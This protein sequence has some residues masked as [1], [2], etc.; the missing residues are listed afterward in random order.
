MV[1]NTKYEYEDGRLSAIGLVTA[2][3]EKLPLPLLE[4]YAQLFFMPLVLQLVND[5]SKDCREAVA[6]CLSRL[7]SRASVDVVQSFYDYAVRW[8]QGT[9][10]LQRTSLQLF[11]MFVDARLD[12]MKR[13]NNAEELIDRIYIHLKRSV[14]GGLDE[15]EVPY[16]S[17]VCLEKL[18]VPFSTL[19]AQRSDLWL[20][21]VECLV[22][23][24]PWV[25]QVSSRMVGTH[26]AAMDPTTFVSKKAETFLL[27]ESGS[28]FEVAQNLC[29]QLNVGEPEQNKE[30]STTAIKSLTWIIQ[31]MDEHP[32]LCFADDEVSSEEDDPAQSRKNP[33]TWL[34]TRLS[35]MAKPKGRQ[36]RENVFKC[37]AAFT[38]YGGSSIVSP[39][40]VLMLE[41]LHRSIVEVENVTG[42]SYNSRRTSETAEEGN[43][44]RDVLQLL[45]DSCGT[46]S[47]LEAY[48]SVKVRA[49]EKREQ[50]KQQLATEAVQDPQ[51]AATRK[52]KKHQ[53]ERKR[54]K[55]KVEERRNR[56]G[57]FA[58][59]RHVDYD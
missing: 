50:R 16:F 49:R 53:S 45:E 35:N 38:T 41:P 25:K 46:D 42:H 52:I 18:S 34:M 57:G 24:H 30:L 54:Q 29:A 51:A 39:Y 23:P 32:H 43:L 5:E 58:K 4:E 56:R 2:V 37:F 17:L 9:D 40:L 11:G 1:L 28:L 20:V 47:F 33:V 59:R 55:R 7:L 22:N 13:G 31:A 15:W 36:R 14:G 26:L 48:A 44:A 3:I 6:K 19:V 8:S 27:K 21:I 10:N 12:F